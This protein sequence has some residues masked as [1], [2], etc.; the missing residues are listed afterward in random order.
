MKQLKYASGADYVCIGIGILG[1]FIAGFNWPVLTILFGDVVDI[2]IEFERKYN[3]I[4]NETERSEL[5]TSFMKQVY[6]YS[7]YSLANC[8]VF[9]LGNFLTIYFFQ[10]F[11]MRIVKRI[12]QKY[13]DS[14]LR[15]E[16]AWFDKQNSG[17]FASRIAG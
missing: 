9:I 12:K 4:Q 15:Q 3:T 1:S 5:L 2:F 16:I 17:E 11:A 6:L 13:F 10:M 14:I 7:G 8:A